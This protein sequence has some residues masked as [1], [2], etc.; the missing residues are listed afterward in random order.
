LQIKASTEFSDQEKQLREKSI[1][2]QYDKELKEYRRLQWQK[3]A[4][5]NKSLADMEATS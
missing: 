1:R 3:L 4:E 5:Y 2:A